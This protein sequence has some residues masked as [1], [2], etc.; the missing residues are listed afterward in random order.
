M[1]GEIARKF[2]NRRVLLF[3]DNMV[4]MHVLTNWYSRSKLLR[5]EVRRILDMVLAHNIDLVALY[6]NTVENALADHL[7]R[8]VEEHRLEICEDTMKCLVN[9]L[10]IKTEIS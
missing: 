9:I 5:M 4:V 1:L 10:N 7:S 2:R 8:V 3:T 6:I